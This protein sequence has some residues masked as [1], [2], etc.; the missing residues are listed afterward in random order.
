MRGT[1]ANHSLPVQYNEING[2]NAVSSSPER[3]RTQRIGWLGAAVLAV[4]LYVPAMQQAFGTVGLRGSDWLRCVLA[5]SAVV[6]RREI[7]KMFIRSRHRG[8][9]PE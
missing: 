1:C 8:D 2:M 9:W 5:A 7:S 3:H 6:W 4:V